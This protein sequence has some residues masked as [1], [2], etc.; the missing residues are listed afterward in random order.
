MAKPL[1]VILPSKLIVNCLL[2]NVAEKSINFIQQLIQNLQRSYRRVLKSLER[3]VWKAFIAT[4]VIFTNSCSFSIVS[5]NTIL[6]YLNIP[7]INKPTGLDGI[8][9]RF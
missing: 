1:Q 5:E 9:S 2:I 6:K 7:G 3:S 8:R 4:K